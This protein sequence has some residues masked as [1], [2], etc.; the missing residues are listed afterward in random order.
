[1]YQAIQLATK[2]R[3]A[4]KVM[5][6]N[7]FAG[8]S[9]R[10]RFEREV[11]ILG[12]LSHPNIVRI[13]DSGL[14]PGAAGAFYY[15]MDY[16]SGRS[17]EE[18]I[19]GSKTVPVPEIVRLFTRICDAVN[20]AHLR[21]VIHRDLKPS[22]IRINPENEP[23]V[24]DF[25]LAKVA[26]GDVD[27]AGSPKLMTMTGQ[28]VGSLPW[29]SPEQAEGASGGI[30]VRTDVYSLGV[31]LYQMLTGGKFPYEV[32]GNMRDVLENILRAEPARPSTIRRQINDEV[33][34]IVLKCL[35]KE[36]DRR[37]QTAGELGRDLR[38][39]LTG[40]PI[41]AKRDSVRY[42]IGKTLKR[43]RYAAGVGVGF[44]VLL[45]AFSV[46]M[47][48]MYR[49]AKLGWGQAET[50]LLATQAAQSQE[51]AERKRAE[52]NFGVARDLWRTFMYDFDEQLKDLRGTT[53]T[54]EL[55]LSKAVAAVATLQ[56]QAGEDPELLRELA[57]AHEKV[58]D[59]RGALFSQ[60]L[61]ETAQAAGDYAASRKIRE[62]LAARFPNDWRATL[63]LAKSLKND[64]VLAGAARK[65]EEFRGLIA[66][67]SEMAGRAVT[68]ATLARDDAGI[69]AARRLHGVLLIEQ[70]NAAYRLA[71][72]ND[73]LEQASG[74][75]TQADA[76]FTSAVAFW[77][78]ELERDPADQEAAAYAGKAKDYLAA[79][80][81]LLGQRLAGNDELSEDEKTVA[82]ARDARR[83]R[84]VRALAEYAA[85]SRI[86]SE[87]LAEFGAM[88][89]ARPESA[90][91]RRDVMLAHHSLGLASMRAARAHGLLAQLGEAGQEELRVAADELS[92]R[93]NLE[94]LGIARAL[95]ASDESNIEAMRD[96]CVCLNK[97]G[98]QQRDLG[99]RAEAVATFDESLTL[100]RDMFASDPIQ[101]HRRDLAVGLYKAGQV[102][103]QLAGETPEAQRRPV[104]E[105]SRRLLAESLGQF[106]ALRD[107]GVLSP[108]A[109]DLKVCAG[110]LRDVET[111]LQER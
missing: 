109:R 95:A 79:D 15:V 18:Y 73:D 61:G 50:N 93:H 99:R 39:Y 12:Q 4:I 2:R 96:L 22:N 42:F 48:F 40:E 76:V 31:I 75:L 45:V 1:V 90:S 7:R 53:R 66:R 55:V 68:Q 97:V 65:F 17:L 98:N 28:F 92:L 110:E 104:L 84:L 80:R 5:H 20:A 94:A 14:T 60:R 111:R 78:Q 88:S 38:R 91:L 51:E 8:S 23:I 77:R 21:G 37:Y 3:V 32:V 43:Y 58:G 57:D 30:D 56:R 36:R 25:G 16:V 103:S 105:E 71:E 64:A 100:R 63:D 86:S 10:A 89:A 35:S 102:R 54:R 74:L 69:A 26:V 49:H 13:H 87:A 47:G 19:S 29:A 24:L 34:T 27:E 101:Q 85:A 6:D 106:Q 52:Q 107:A 33:E 81:V 62:A 59:L 82:A 46:A 41:E 83:Q 11:Q 67:A 44:V 70:G 72:N 108:E 9:G